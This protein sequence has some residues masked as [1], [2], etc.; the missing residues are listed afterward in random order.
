[1]FVVVNKMMCISEG[2][3]LL[4]QSERKQDI[5]INYQLFRISSNIWKLCLLNHYQQS[6]YDKPLD[7]SFSSYSLVHSK[8]ATEKLVFYLHVVI[9]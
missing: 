5:R 1:M 2:D 7:N 6:K 8:R 4:L 9:W 3:A